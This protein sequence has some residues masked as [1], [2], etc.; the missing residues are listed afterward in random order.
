M[1]LL[2]GPQLADPCF[3]AEVGPLLFIVGAALQ[4]LQSGDTLK[5]DPL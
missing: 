5:F 1:H 3:V 2:S 4:K